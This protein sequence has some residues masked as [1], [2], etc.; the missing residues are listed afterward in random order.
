M[1]SLSAMGALHMGH[2]LLTRSSLA[3]QSRQH[4]WPHPAAHGS[5]GSHRHTQHISAPAP[6]PAPAPESKEEVKEV[7]ASR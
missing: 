3:Q 4:T 2:S 7:G 1:L 5:L 6:A